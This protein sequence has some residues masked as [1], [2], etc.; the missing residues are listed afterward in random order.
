MATRLYGKFR[1]SGCWELKKA[2]FG[3]F[4]FYNNWMQT[5]KG[6]SCTS[7]RD[8]IRLLCYLET[9]F[10]CIF[11][12]F[13]LSFKIRPYSKCECMQ[14][15]YILYIYIIIYFRLLSYDITLYFC[16]LLYP[17]TFQKVDRLIETVFIYHF[18]HIYSAFIII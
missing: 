2:N 5:V 12:F 13:R 15:L 7:S 10:L 1:P 18:F 9:L 14:L 16:S 4:F 8:F 3:L 11:L 6:R 17:S